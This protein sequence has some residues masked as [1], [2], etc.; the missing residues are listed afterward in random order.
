MVFVRCPEIMS[1]FAEKM[2]Q[3]GGRL[4][5]AGERAKLKTAS[6]AGDAARFWQKTRQRPVDWWASRRAAPASTLDGAWPDSGL[7]APSRQD[8]AKAPAPATQATGW[9]ADRP[10]LAKALHIAA[11]VIG[12]YLVLPYVLIVLFW[13]LDPPFSALMLRHALT[14]REINFEWADFKDISPN[15]ARAAVIAEDARFCQHSGVDWNAVGEALE[16]MEDGDTPRGASTIPM[17]TAKNLFLWSD[18]SYLR[19]ALEVPLAYFLSLLWS[20]QR[21][22]EIYLNIAEWGPG[23]YGAEAASLYHFG[24]P[25]ASLSKS[26]AALLVAALPSP[27]KRNAGRPSPRMQ[28]L[29][30]RIQSRVD[31][32]AQD[33]ACVFKR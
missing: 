22:L 5:S 31:R 4:K 8:T 30:S 17:Q 6:A 21:V 10:R 32:E 14:G 33:A 13:V 16:D 11:I 2:R 3:I 24:K 15:L 25:A 26:E 20:K 18:Q 28:R 12:A 19:K 23:I 29:A 9:R 27:L 7:D 1:L